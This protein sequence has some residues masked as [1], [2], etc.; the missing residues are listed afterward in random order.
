MEN[1]YQQ[2]C[3]ILRRL[4]VYSHY[5]GF[6]QAAYA[7]ALCVEEPS[8]RNSLIEQVYSAT[9]EWFNTS[10]N[11]VERNIR[12]VSRR[13]W[14]KNRTGLEALTGTPLDSAPGPGLFLMLLASVLEPVPIP[15][16]SGG[17]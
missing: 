13:V 5:K 11:S 7:A 10:W 12:T 1:T 2:M 6:S 17:R 16:R 3:A 4:G 14:K 8:R 9:A 15:G